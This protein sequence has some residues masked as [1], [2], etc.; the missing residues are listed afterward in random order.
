[1]SPSRR[2]RSAVAVAALTLTAAS[3]APTAAQA[4]SFE[5]VSR[6]TG[7]A[8]WATFTRF[9]VPIVVSDTGRFAV[10]Q[11]RTLVPSFAQRF[12]V[13]DIVTNTTTPLAENIFEVYGIDRA[14]GQLLAQ[15]RTGLDINLALLPLAGGTPK[16]LATSQNGIPSAVISGDGKTVAYSF[17]DGGG[18]YTVDLATEKKTKVDEV[19]YGLGPRSLSDD[20]TVLAGTDATNWPEA[21]FVWRGGVKTLVP[22][23][24]VI[25]PDGAVAATS[26]FRDGEDYLSVRTLATGVTKEFPIPGDLD[27][28]SAISGDGQKITVASYSG[29]ETPA[30]VLDV[31]SGTFRPVASKYIESVVDASLAGRDFRGN[32]DA[33]VFSR[34][35][36]YIVSSARGG[37][38][39]TLNLIDLWNRDLPGV[40]EAPSPSAYVSIGAP[41]YSCGETTKTFTI[42]SFVRSSWFPM[43]KSVAVTITIDGKVTYR[44]TF[45]APGPFD[46]TSFPTDAK[47]I[48]YKVSVV[49]AAG[50][51]QT[52][53]ET[54]APTL[55]SGFGGCS[56]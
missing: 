43:A 56:S 3:L 8:G 27:N 29:S 42:A 19:S 53:T 25:S 40:Q 41:I 48:I 51:T 5:Q 35:G 6:A 9:A 33:T 45:T 2:R 34:N 15:T 11:Y 28:L 50:K 55:D 46:E 10:F 38:G 44:K 21:A 49:D 7:A 17:D 54:V 18:T 32:G 30:Q 13:R 22:G 14:E 23:R 47:S 12:Y 4:G 24:S 37:F 36:R 26:I 52:T 39:N 16:V 20:G 1:M 31:P